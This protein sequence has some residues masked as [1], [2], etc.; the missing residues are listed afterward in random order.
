MH[1]QNRTAMVTFDFIIGILAGLATWIQ[2][3]SFGDNAWRLFAT[4][5]ALVAAI[6][7]IV[8]ALV[9]LLS[10]RRPIGAEVCPM[11]Q[12]GLIVS[13]I[14]LLLI[15]I[16]YYVLDSYIPSV[17]MNVILIEFILP[18]LMIM[19][20]V[21]FSTKGK[22][23][24]Y[25]PFYWLALPAVYVA[26]ILVSGELMPRSASL[27][28]PYEFLDYPS[29]GID[30][31]LWWLAI[32]ATATL[33]VGYIFWILDFALSGKLAEHIVMPKIKTVVIEEEVEDEEPEVVEKPKEKPVKLVTTGSRN[34]PV[35]EAQQAA[36]RTKNTQAKPK[37]ST[38]DEKSSK[39]SS[40]T[41]E[42]KP[43]VTNAKKTK[44]TE[45]K[46]EASGKGGKQ[47]APKPESENESKVARV[48]AK[49]KTERGTMLK[50]QD[51]KPKESDT[52]KSKPSA[53]AEGNKPDSTPPV[54]IIE[55]IDLAGDKGNEEKTES[56]KK[57]DMKQEVVIKD[58]QKTVVT[59]P[60][61]ESKAQ[62]QDNVKN[63]A[64]KAE[65]EPE[66]DQK[67]TS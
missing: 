36:K 33:I 37:T 41:V 61:S 5:V 60:I 14:L 40:K 55:K 7:Y 39:K 57:S 59:K 58:G 17:G 32:F 63:T 42:A 25:E 19:S 35:I 31:M 15:R 21:M 4:W 64:K 16:V 6:Y 52:Q 18:I 53:K 26:L 46:P 27:V 66:A 10:K 1:I 3:A 28:Y 13:G 62:A 34:L 50:T 54:R 12:G 9:A 30:T 47:T 20:W 11:L 43:Q 48:E 45:A 51:T 49:P 22:W 24:A 56:T 67:V 29:I 2:F 44:Q 23:R 8:D 65:D 38:N